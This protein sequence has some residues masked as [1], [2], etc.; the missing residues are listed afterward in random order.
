M[1]RKSFSPNGLIVS[2]PSLSGVSRDIS[3]ASCRFAQAGVTAGQE[4]EAPPDAGG[5]PVGLATTRNPNGKSA[6]ST[7]T[8]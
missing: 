3:R 4:G 6:I 8:D 5:F 7:V 1:K 2:R